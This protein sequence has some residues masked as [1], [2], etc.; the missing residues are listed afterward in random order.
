MNIVKYVFEL[1]EKQ[2]ILDRHLA[3]LY[4]VQTKHLKQ[5]VRRNWNRFPV[6]FMFELSHQELIHWRSQFVTSNL[7]ED[8]NDNM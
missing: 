3:S 1:R 2:V 6:D 4:G 8:M 5:A 7:E